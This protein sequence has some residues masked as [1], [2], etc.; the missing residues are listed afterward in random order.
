MNVPVMRRDL[1]RINVRRSTWDRAHKNSI[2]AALVPSR[3]ESIDIRINYYVKDLQERSKVTKAVF[4]SQGREGKSYIAVPACGGSLPEARRACNQSTP[5]AILARSSVTAFQAC[6][7]K[8]G[9]S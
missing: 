5:K 6:R 7:H 4:G 3:G 2:R 1:S 9:S 8:L